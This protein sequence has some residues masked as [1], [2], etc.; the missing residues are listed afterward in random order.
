MICTS[1]LMIYT[2][3]LI[4]YYDMLFY[5]W[6]TT[7]TTL[8]SFVVP[9]VNDC[10][11][12]QYRALQCP[13]FSS[14]FIV[15]RQSKYPFV[16]VRILVPNEPNRY[17]LLGVF[18]QVIANQKILPFK[19]FL[20]AKWLDRF[21]TPKYVWNITLLDFVGANN[22]RHGQTP[23]TMELGFPFTLN[24]ATLNLYKN[25]IL[26]FQ[27]MKQCILLSSMSHKIFMNFVEILKLL[28][29]FEVLVKKICLNYKIYSK[30]S[31]FLLNVYIT[32]SNIMV[33]ENQPFI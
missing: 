14:S 20:L 11:Q 30:T 24:F 10:R 13:V 32:M 26:Y 4:M 7:L 12:K 5:T 8:S 27:Q 33:D 28:Q 19:N 3:T 29:I 31:N 6:P 2:F 15:Y 25:Q 1:T 23:M 9:T 22:G 16:F 18:H 21:S 17:C